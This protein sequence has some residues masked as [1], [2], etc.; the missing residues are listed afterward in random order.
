VPLS[1]ESDTVE[2]IIAFS[3]GSAGERC[4]ACSAVVVVGDGNVFML[5]LLLDGRLASERS[6]DG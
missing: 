2:H 4:M 1:A 3:F 5:A 6:G